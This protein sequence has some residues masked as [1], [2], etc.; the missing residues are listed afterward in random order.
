MALAIPD[1]Y[2]ATDS[3]D[4]PEDSGQ[5]SSPARMWADKPI[6]KL[7]PG[8]TA[9]VVRWALGFTEKTPHAPYEQLTPYI[10]TSMTAS[11]NKGGTHSMKI[12]KT[13]T[14]AS[15][16]LVEICSTEYNQIG[17]P[18]AEHATFWDVVGSPSELFPSF[19]EDSIVPLGLENIVLCHSLQEK[20]RILLRSNGHVWVAKKP[21]E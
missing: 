18:T 17:L 16:Y 3:D 20:G 5:N 1:A 6:T 8:E 13:G 12:K 7:L 19:A 11:P 10:C 9:Y 4:F 14:G 2:L 15:D 21:Q